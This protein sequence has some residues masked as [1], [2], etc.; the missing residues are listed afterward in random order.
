MSIIVGQNVLVALSKGQ[1]ATVASGDWIK[2]AELSVQRNQNNVSIETA[3]GNISTLL[4]KHKAGVDYE[5]TVKMPID[6]KMV[7]HLLKAMYGAVSEATDSP[8]AGV[9]TEAF[10]IDSGSPD[11]YTI[12]VIDGTN[13]YQF[14][15]AV[16][17]GLVF[18]LPVS[19]GLYVTAT[20]VANEFSTT[21]GL[22]A[23]YADTS[24]FKTCQWKFYTASDYSGIGSA[25]E[26]TVENSLDVEFAR[27]VKINRVA[28]S[29]DVSSVVQ[30]DWTVSIKVD[31]VFD[32][33][34]DSVLTDVKA[35]TEKAFRVKLIDT[36]TTLGTSTNPS[37]FIDIP[38]GLKEE[39][40]RDIAI[41]DVVGE[42]YSVVATKGDIANGVSVAQLITDGT[43]Y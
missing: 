19:D 13:Q 29:C 38:S 30:T 23:S 24:L 7:G 12:S 21:S 25:T 11:V 41:K 43:G 10:T 6:R 16:L 31:G 1:S 18:N 40:N 33:S 28:G 3:D 39:Y 14:T 36:D 34:D 8:E 2:W 32:T 5:I 26:L 22:S 20:F 35:M 17:K 4:A 37:I 42:K 15:Y 27:E 9:N